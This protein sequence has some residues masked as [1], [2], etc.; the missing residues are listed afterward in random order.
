MRP[1]ATAPRGS[2]PRSTS[3]AAARSR[4]CSCEGGPTLAGALFDAGEIDAM[5]LF[6]APVLVGAGE[7]RAVLEGEGRAAHRRGP[8]AARDQH[9][10]IGEDLLITAA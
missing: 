9:E 4:T 10:P 2:A 6:I 5:S 1:G 7:A 8:A 3:S